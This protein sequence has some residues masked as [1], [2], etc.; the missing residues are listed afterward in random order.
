MPFQDLLRT[1]RSRESQILAAAF[2]KHRC[3]EFVDEFELLLPLHRHQGT[4]IT[5]VPDLPGLAAAVEHRPFAVW[6]S[7]CESSSGGAG[8]GYRI[9]DDAR[10]CA[11]SLPSHE[12]CN[13]TPASC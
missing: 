9:L 11:T 12:G 10:Q 5:P 3:F 1:T 4:G 8:L 7:P 2:D 13:P 6:I